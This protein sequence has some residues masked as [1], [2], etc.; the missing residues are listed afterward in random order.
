MSKSKFKYNYHHSTN[1]SYN[2]RNEELENLIEQFNY[3]YDKLAT[4]IFTIE[5]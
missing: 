2:K 1:L 3:A 5:D 4:K